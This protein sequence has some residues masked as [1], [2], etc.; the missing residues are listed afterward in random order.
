MKQKIIIVDNN[1]DV[2]RIYEDTLNSAGYE[3]VS[4]TDEEKALET[5]CKEAPDLVLLD[6]L[7]PRISG[8]HLLEMI[9]KDKC[10]RN[11]NVAILTELTDSNVRDKALRKGACDYIIKHETDMKGLLRHVREALE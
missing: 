5:I 9:K 2:C 7:M 6:I 11:V 10:A 3:A 1:R 4:I 8:L